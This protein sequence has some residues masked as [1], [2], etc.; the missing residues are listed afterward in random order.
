MFVHEVHCPVRSMFMWQREGQLNNVAGQM[1][2]VYAC[3]SLMKVNT[4]PPLQCISTTITCKNTRQKCLC[5]IFNMNGL[6][7][8][9]TKNK[10]SVFH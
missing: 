7:T 3:E 9:G 10:N 5:L 1:V 4:P 8:N 6:K 2:P